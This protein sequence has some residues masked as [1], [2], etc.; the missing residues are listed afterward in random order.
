MTNTISSETLTIIYQISVE[1]GKPSWLE[2][3]CLQHQRF[4]DSGW[5]PSLLSLLGRSILAPVSQQRTMRRQFQLPLPSVQ[6]NTKT[7]I[8]PNT[9]TRF[10]Y[11]NIL[12]AL[13]VG[14]YAAKRKTNRNELLFCQ[15]RANKAGRY[16]DWLSPS[17]P[18][19]SLCVQGLP[20]GPH[21]ANLV[22]KG[23]CQSTGVSSNPANSTLY[24][25]RVGNV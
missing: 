4:Y 22:T 8:T 14:G 5:T 18:E 21:G 2:Y 20:G 23:R 7:I 16:A 15:R 24:E 13:F 3:R 10:I 19:R 17:V 11:S 9:N 1:I 25:L 6:T 12:L